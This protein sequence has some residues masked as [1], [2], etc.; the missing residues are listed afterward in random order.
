MRTGLLYIPKRIPAERI[1]LAV[2]FMVCISNGVVAQDTA[3]SKQ[4]STQ[5]NLPLKNISPDKIKVVSS[6]TEGSRLPKKYIC[7]GYAKNTCKGVQFYF[8]DTS[9][10]EVIPI[11]VKTKRTEPAPPP[12]QVKKPFVTVHGN[13]MYDL[14]YRSRIDTPFASNDVYQH[15]ISTY[16]TVKVKD[17]YP[18]RVYFTTRF[19]NNDYFK[20][21]TN[22]NTQF[23]ARQFRT[24]VEDKLRQTLIAQVP[25][26]SRL[27]MLRTS[28]TNSIDEY[29]K[30]RDW[31]NS[32]SVL[33]K[34]V[35]EKEAELVRLKS[36]A[37][38]QTVIS[39]IKPENNKTDSILQ[40]ANSVSEK[41]K[42]PEWL[43]TLA[44]QK[45]QAKADSL[46]SKHPK[47]DSL[48][49][50]FTQY[51]QKKKSQIDSLQKKIDTL[52]EKYTAEKNKII[53]N[54][55]SLVRAF[56]SYKNPAALKEKIES[57]GIADSSLPK[58]Y[59]TLLAIK[60]FSIGRGIV[61]YSELT[62]KNVSIT[63]LQVEYNP[64]Y[65]YAIAA[66]TIDYRFRDFIINNDGTNG[67]YLGML[68]FGKGQKEGTHLIGT[69]YFG[70]RQ[71]YNYSSY[72][73]SFGI[74]QP[75]YSLMGISLEAAYQLNKTTT[76]TAEAAKSSAPYY[77]R[78]I[79]K[80]GVLQSTLKFS[81]HSNEAYSIKLNT[82]ITKTDTKL[83]GYYKHYGANFQSFT[84]FTSSSAQ[85]AW[86]LQLSQ[87]F[88][89]KQLSV[90]GSVRKNDYVSPYLDQSYTSNTVFKTLQATL[91]IKKWPVLSVGYYPTSQLTKLG[92]DK[93]TENL[94]YTFVS[95]ASYFYKLGKNN[96][97]SMLMF[98]RFY[99]RPADSGYLF[100]NTK[101]ILLNHTM[102]FRNL[103]LQG[104]LSASINP[105]Y[106]LYVAG[107]N[108]QVKCNDW[109]SLGGGLK[110][111]RETKIENIQ[112]GYNLNST[113]KIKKLGDFMLM[114]EKGFL[115]GPDKELVPN[116]I[117][118]FTF[119]RNF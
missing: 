2:I 57:S 104:S 34:L 56:N 112:L 22:L 33:Q 85:D 4:P 48:V 35:E 47:A 20:N 90:T 75:N 7:I 46:E 17:N 63:G 109:L 108:M 83:S 100:F 72:D 107:T 18:F 78:T 42:G 101:N 69:Y 29:N 79:D 41:I 23:D 51:Y 102:F 95:S 50:S 54:K 68:R 8:Y 66:G 115:P 97:S 16:L 119:L 110:Y 38:P 30:L 31:V 70:K 32:S 71:L 59:K 25:D 13:V 39:T 117:G 94:F 27:S 77:Q 113:I 81:D 99:N 24:S 106:N 76:I 118:R 28:L 80:T 5:N 96:M 98:T 105:E 116:N 36:Q 9:T 1:L 89:K 64:K 26:T 60:S 40:T 43:V 91:R 61:D 53:Q 11:L 37:N 44:K 55:D 3:Q 93:F 82:A 92:D 84:L 45:L 10:V 103:T 86:Q 87:N 114:G 12:P 74:E 19:T 15:T 21:F 73:T 62:A 14:Y 67:Q 49:E 65:Y 88:F 58:G 6:L 111:N 52:E